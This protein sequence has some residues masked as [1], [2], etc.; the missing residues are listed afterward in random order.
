M[1]PNIL[2][3]QSDQHR[4]DCMGV[5]G[6]PMLQTPHLDQ[7]AAE[8]MNFTHAF[9]PIPM[10]VSTRNSLM[11]GQWPTGHLAIT[12]WNTE[13]PRPAKDGLPTFSQSL[14]ECGYT[15]G[16]VGKWHIHPHKNALDYGFH[17]YVPIKQYTSW[18][19]N[20]GL[21]PRPRAQ[22]WLGEIDPHITPEE[23][24]L[25]WSAN[26]VIRLLEQ[27]AQT[28]NPFFIRWDPDEPH[29]PNIVPEPY[30]SMYPP[31]NLPSWPNF[32]DSLSGKPYIQ[33]QQRRTWQIENW[34][35]DDWAPVVSRYLG[36]ISLLDAQIGR[37]LAALAALGLAG[38]TLV[39]YT[40]DHGDLCGGHG[41]I[42]KHFI[43]YDEV[44]RV[45]LIIRWPGVIAAG[46]QNDAFIIN[47][48]DL[49]ATFCDVAG[50]PIPATFSGQSLVPLVKGEKAMRRQD[51]YA[52]YHG[53]QFG[54]FTQRMVRDYHW[55]YVWNAT[56]ED[57]LY[58]LSSDP[59]ELHNLATDLAAQPEL[60]R[61]RHRLVAW[62]EET[63]DLILNPWIKTQLL[64]G[65]KR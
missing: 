58:H 21:P 60:T 53:C 52:M 20:Q 43:M 8:G 39:V 26:L 17:V 42:D 25:A 30:F 46:S 23:S 13:T 15:L 45:P 61:L 54:L 24:K 48:L 56:A 33:Q 4:F 10:C 32:P 62:M 44:V 5:N 19:V 38:K 7:L 18:R 47:A 3:I 2:L 57:E 14:R 9:C 16:Y 50:A 63:R 64:E 55:K 12:N 35:W 11:Y 22:G 49:A 51:V 6:H 59:A 34:T 65:L 28:N 31:E 1:Q 41:M 36:E 27:A 29:L 40:T 37:V